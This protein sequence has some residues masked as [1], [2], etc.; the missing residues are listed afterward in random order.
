MITYLFLGLGGVCLLLFCLLRDK[1]SSAAAIAFKTLASLFFVA[2]AIAAYLANPHRADITAPAL[3]MIGGLVLGLVGDIT[4]DFKIFLKGL[5]YDSAERDADIMT[6]TGMAA[7]AVGHILYIVAAGLRFGWPTALLWSALVA[8]GT[9]AAIF[10]LSL[11]VMKMRFGKFLLPSILY[12]FLLSWFVVFS[13]WQ[14]IAVEGGTAN[15]LLAIGAVMFIVSDLILSITYFSKEA[16]YQRQG[17]LHPESKLMIV[18]N[19][20]TYY[21]AQFLIAVAILAL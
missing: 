12:G 9:I 15:V 11:G 20:V 8:L 7:F 5:P 4:L 3:L 2:T 1:R 16:D 13:I 17:P 21:I 6:Y 18:A 10:G 14:A 19:H